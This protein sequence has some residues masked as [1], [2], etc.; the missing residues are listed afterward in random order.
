MARIEAVGVARARAGSTFTW[1]GRIALPTST[2]TATAELSSCLDGSALTPPAVTV[3]AHVS[4]EGE[5][6]PV[7]PTGFTLYDVVLL[8]TSAQTAAWPRQKAGDPAIDSFC[9]VLFRDAGG[10]V[11][12]AAFTV[13]SKP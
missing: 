2:Y 5:T 8:A 9:V 11:F 6:L 10:N 7:L 1:G 4:V 3:P 13:R 12:D